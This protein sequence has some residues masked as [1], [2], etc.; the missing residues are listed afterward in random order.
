M[1]ACLGAVREVLLV[2]RWALICPRCRGAKAV[3]TSLDQLPQGAH[4]PSCNI[5]FDRDFSRNVEVTFD[6]ADDIRPLGT[7]IYC[8]ASPVAAEHIKAQHRPPPGPPPLVHAKLA[9]GHY[10]CP[11]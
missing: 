1:E 5:P 6:P 8:L 9:P 11:T 7:G 2:L 10:P 4:C 3:V